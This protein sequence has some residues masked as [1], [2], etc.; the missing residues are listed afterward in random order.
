MTPEEAEEIRSMFTSIPKGEV[1][2]MMNI[3]L[4]RIIE[5]DNQVNRLQDRVNNVEGQVAG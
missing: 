2:G 4:E 3:L 1:L 5:L